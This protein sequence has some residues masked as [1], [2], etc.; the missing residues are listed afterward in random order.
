MVIGCLGCV[1]AVKESRPLLLTVN[2]FEG[3]VPD[4]DTPPRWRLR[5]LR[6][7]GCFFFSC[8][9]EKENQLCLTFCRERE[10]EGERGWNECNYGQCLGESNCV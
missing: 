5:G 1:G 7:D 10:R 4:L 9:C 3:G 8:V 6:T 2:H